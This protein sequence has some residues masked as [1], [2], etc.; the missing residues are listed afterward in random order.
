MSIK[1]RRTSEPTY[2][3]RFED[4]IAGRAYESSVRTVGMCSLYGHRKLFT[5][6]G[7]ASYD[8]C[9][10]LRYRAVSVEVHIE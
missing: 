1:I 5:T 4:L 10:T 7:G 9:A 2:P 3:F 8:E 6:F